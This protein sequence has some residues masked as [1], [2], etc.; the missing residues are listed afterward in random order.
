MG[1]AHSD[2]RVDVKW[3]V[4]Q[5]LVGGALGDLQGGGMREP[6]RCAHHEGLERVAGVERRTLEI[7]PGRFF[8][9]VWAAGTTRNEIGAAGAGCCLGEA[10]AS[11]AAGAALS[12]STAAR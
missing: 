5:G 2:T 8:R 12:F 9:P 11:L 7:R 4:P 3:I 1:F 6:V 10:M